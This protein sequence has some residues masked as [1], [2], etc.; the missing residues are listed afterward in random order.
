MIRRRSLQVRLQHINAT[1]LAVAVNMVTVAIV[2]SGFTLG[3]FGLIDSTRVQ[4]QL[5]AQNAAAAL[6]FDDERAA[7]RLLQSLRTA[8][9]IRSAALYRTDG[10]LLT[11]FAVE[12]VPA[13][14]A[15]DFTPG[16]L[17]VHLDSIVL[18]EPVKS[19]QDNAGHLLLTASLGNLYRQT[20]LQMLLTL[21]AAL[22]ALLASHILLRRLQ[23][24][25]L[26]PLVALNDL[27]Q[28]AAGSSNYT[29]RAGRSEIAELDTLGKGFNSMLAQIGDNDARLAAHSNHLEEEV[30]VRT[31]EL[32]R[33]KEV[34]E[35][36]SRAKSEFLATMSHEIRTP[37]NGVL[38]MNELLIDSD[39][40]P[41]QRAWAEAVRSS[42]SHLLNVINDILDFSK[43]ESGQL[44]LESIDFS[45]VE[46]VEEA[47]SMFVQPAQAKGLE[48]AAQFTPQD[49][50][51]TLRGDPLRL[52]QVLANLISNAI[53]FTEVGEVVIRVNLLAETA[54]DAHIG[55]SVEDTGAGIPVEVQARIF[56]HFSQA[57]GST[58]R[59]HGGTGLGLAICRRLLNL[60]GGSIRVES[61]PREGA[62]FYVEFRSP[63]ATNLSLAPLANSLLKGVSVLVVDDH[64]TNRDIM[65][66]QFLG[67]GMQVS[68]A[69]NGAAALLA[70][71][72]ASQSGHPFDIAVLDMHMPGMDGMQLA[73]AIYAMPTPRPKL[74]ILSS[75]YANRSPRVARDFGIQRHL[76]KPVRRADLFRAVTDIIA[77]VQ[78]DATSRHRLVPDIGPEATGGQV[79]LVEDN[80][81]N[82]AVA[83]A[84]LGKFGLAVTLATNG[85]QAVEMVQAKV[86][87]L[88]LMDC[89]MPGMDGFEAT[90]RIRAMERERGQRTPLPIVA[91]T[92][93][94]MA[95]DR[96]T[97]L[98]AG[99]SDYLT[100]PVTGA[101]L[102]EM[103]ARHLVARE[104]IA[105]RAIFDASLLD[106]LPMVA[107]GSDTGFA[108]QV[109]AQ[110][111]DIGASQLDECSKAL[112]AGDDKTTLR[113]VH[114]LKS[115]SAQV[116][117]LDVAALAADIETGMRLG[118]RL[119]AL[120]LAKL[121][122]AFNQA[123][124]AIHRHRGI[125]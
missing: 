1:A 91:L 37:M 54:A 6:L 29:L 99:M 89:Q 58:T 71:E 8:P 53:K 44:E 110:Y 114:T 67:W 43:I 103:I 12:G 76:H 121:D 119:D 39:L 92:A 30:A 101:R 66:Q 98:A 109:L 50:P 27:M 25:L 82:Q 3:L 111:L 5:L 36:A 93:N 113:C 9:A 34:A 87:D 32:Q 24:P 63:K 11:S 81:I 31:S 47:L 116:G 84:M 57:D 68:T 26:Q 38:G 115:S 23:A 88:V 4:A 94:A 117:A 80:P 61:A 42:S 15:T 40:K 18:S 14:S 60:M 28:R 124:Q 48:L 70:I 10:E 7:G 78:R 77:A 83:S 123:A 120:T 69:A 13:A 17:R 45:L 22:V 21:L 122:D 52:R 73:E 112:A 35:A 107:D 2:I 102:A 64:K 46:V 41:Q 96:E 105:E 86:F 104:P 65:Q 108:D 74:I 79:L 19:L 56:E 95:G 55:I 97:C 33:A 125:S 16:G 75:A 118:Q 59:R 90:R 85:L 20:L 100:K 72:G 51:L 62:K 106:K 49:A